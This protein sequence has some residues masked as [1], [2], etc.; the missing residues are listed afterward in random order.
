[1]EKSVSKV[2]MNDFGEII[3]I[4]QEM[5]DTTEEELEEENYK[6]KGCQTDEIYYSSLIKQGNFLKLN[7][8]STQTIEEQL[9]DYFCD[10]CD[11]K[12]AIINLQ[13]KEEDEQ[14]QRLL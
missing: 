3:E 14:N 1:M 13:K 8:I 11:S 4:T 7:E 2:M 9:T 10:A 6:D 5:L 12:L